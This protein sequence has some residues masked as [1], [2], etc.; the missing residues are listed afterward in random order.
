MLDPTAPPADQVGM[1]LVGSAR[2]CGCVS[3]RLEQT[4]ERIFTPGATSVTAQARSM[5]SADPEDIRPPTAPTAKINIRMN[6]PS[7]RCRQPSARTAENV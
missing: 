5:A 6:R 4:P 2:R 3:K 1:A 7:M